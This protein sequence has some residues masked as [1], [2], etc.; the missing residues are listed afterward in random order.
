M[1]TNQTAA[2]MPAPGPIEY[3]LL[4]SISL[5]WGTSYM[6]TKIA[7]GAVPPFTLIALR[8][9][10]AMLAM[11]VVTAMRG[12]MRLSWRDVG[13]F[14]VVGLAVNAAPLSLIALSVSYVHSSVTATTM[15][16]VPLI[17]AL[18]AT[19][20]GEYP[21][22]RN[23]AGIA[24][25][26]VGIVVLF[27]PEAFLSFGASA[28]G[29]TAAIAAAVVFSGSLFSLRLVRQ[30]DPVT[31]TTA[32]LIAAALWTI[33]LALVLEGPPLTFP[34]NDVVG[35]VLVLALV[36]TA[37]SSMLLF[38]LVKRAGATLTSYNNYLVPAVA[39]LCGSV[40][41]GEPLTVQSFAGVALML[42]SV[43]ISTVRYRAAPAPV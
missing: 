8:T 35:A 28:R 27:G 26:L 29:A 32:S 13:A 18:M 9:S 20:W 11:L 25:G 15:A 37:A 2:R 43:A 14:A 33:P 16:L 7:L 38:A 19:A 22:G 31:V 34:P 39:V 5:T 42:A 24:V 6:F 17:T 30:H 40:F 21:T 1:S 41:L 10:I 36:N 4:A 12:G 23:Y 3:V